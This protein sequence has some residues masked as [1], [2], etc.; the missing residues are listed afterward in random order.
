MSWNWLYGFPGEHPA[1]YAPVLRQ[2]PAL[3]HLQPPSGPAR[4]L[5]ERFSPYFDVPALGFPKRRAAQA[6]QHVYDLPEAELDALV[7]LFD[8]EPQGLTEE[9][10]ADLRASLRRWSDG[11]TASALLC[12]DTGEQILIQDRRAGWT[13]RDH[14]IGALW[15]RLAYRAL[16]YGR[17]AP[18]LAERLAS[19]HALDVPTGELRAWLEQ[20]WADGLVF[21]ENDTWLTLAT[22]AEPVKVA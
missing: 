5:L 21:R 20:L 12:E 7:Y 16:E 9:Q 22:R 6:Y 17:S 4:I 8:T 14:T 18:A 13:R 15:Q 2:I 10:A 1:D 11:Y 19:E 3:V